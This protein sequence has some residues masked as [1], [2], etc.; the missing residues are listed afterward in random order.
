TSSSSSSLC[1]V[2]DFYPSSLSPVKRLLNESIDSNIEI[3]QM[4]EQECV[5]EIV[6]GVLTIVPKDKSITSSISSNIE[7]N[8]EQQNSNYNS[9][10]HQKQRSSSIASSVSTPSL[11]EHEQE[12]DDSSSSSSPSSRLSSK[13]FIV[14]Q[15][16]PVKKPYSPIQTEQS[17]DVLDLFSSPIIPNNKTQKKVLDDSLS[18]VSSGSDRRSQIKKQKSNIPRSSSPINNKSTLPSIKG[19][20]ITITTAEKKN[21][22]L[23][24][25]VN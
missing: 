22:I 18:S 2:N 8:S 7:K 23:Q 13:P 5:L 6:D 15:D 14:T 9:S 11:S 21:I 24:V 4:D 20:I 17:N 16:V 12:H 1:K 25:F 19:K 10:K 3:I